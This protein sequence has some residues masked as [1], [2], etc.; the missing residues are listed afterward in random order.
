MIGRLRWPSLAAAVGAIALVTPVALTGSVLTG[1]RSPAGAD[2]GAQATLVVTKGGDRTAPAVASTAAGATFAFYAGVASNPATP[3]D[4]P[5]ATCT[6]T[7]PSGTCSVSVPARTGAGRGYWIREL[8]APLGYTIV[9]SLAVGGRTLTSTPYNQLFTGPVPA[10]ATITLPRATSGASPTARGTLW[11]DAR[12]NPPTPSYCGMRI[13]LLLDTSGAVGNRLSTVK[14][15][16]NGLVDTFTGTS[17]SLAVYQFATH[18]APVKNLTAIPDA[19]AAAP[20]KAAV[21][22]LTA[23]GSVNWD[24]GLWQIAASTVHYD[25]VIMLTGG[26]PTVFGPDAEGTGNSTR[27]LDVENAIY[28]ANALKAKG[29]AVRVIGL[30]TAFR[31]A[32][33]NLAVVGGA[34]LAGSVVSY[35]QLGT[36]LR[37]LA[38]NACRNTVNVVKKLIPYGGDIDDAIPGAGFTFRERT[39]NL[40]PESA[41]TDAA[42]GVATFT[43]PRN[44]PPEPV[45]AKLTENARLGYEL[46]PVDGR[47]AT[48]RRSDGTRIPAT[49][50]GDDGFRTTTIPDDL[51][52]C[53]VYDRP[54]TPIGL[55]QVRVD[56]H[57]I[58]NGVR[59]TQDNAP[60]EFQST[61]SLTNQF[62]PV[63]GQTYSGYTTQ[64]TV[65]IG[66]TVAT[67]M[68]PPGCT[69][70]LADLLG[71]HQLSA[72]LNVFA[73]TNVVTCP[74]GT[75]FPPP[76]GG[77]PSGTTASGTTPSGETA[78]GA[79]TG[80]TATGTLPT[81]GPDLRYPIGAGV[82]AIVAG[83][84]LAALVLPTRYARRHRYP[85]HH[86]HRDLG[87]I[88]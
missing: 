42:S 14:S 66:E 23:G 84:A 18:A 33:D 67:G 56:K 25:A 45:R 34:T 17:T 39:G 76:S 57:W 55:A 49:N 2:G 11:A 73:V 74:A 37:D 87:G 32:E 6:T 88:R 59:Y 28:S 75:S 41:T 63:F 80:G 15:A 46:V 78:G 48:C 27:F 54:T 24:S 71:G 19:A 51:I 16:V 13:A 7:A 53:T 10:G 29:T 43:V 68:L 77:T 65:T 21:N 70:R 31:D 3:A 58:V 35:R 22:S 86:I 52:S 9:Q 83:L 20:V 38:R 47:N 81:T 60:P 26:N 64:D 82:L 62:Q 40:L 4:T 8:T 85:H 72:G 30:G 61:L 5:I 12:I 36:A 1:S 44:Q 79:A 50:V 69:S